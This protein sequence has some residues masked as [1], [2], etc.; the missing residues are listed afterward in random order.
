[1]LERE[2]GV[3]EERISWRLG[4]PGDSDSLQTE[5]RVDFRGSSAHRDR[6]AIM[7]E[8]AEAVQGGR[9][10]LRLSPPTL[11]PD[12]T[13]PT[14]GA[15]TV[16][17]PDDEPADDV[18]SRGPTQ[19]NGESAIDRGAPT[20]P[21]GHETL[22]IM[23]D[24]PTSAHA[25]LTARI[26]R[27]EAD[28]R[29]W[30]NLA[31]TLNRQGRLPEAVDAAREAVRLAPDS[32][33]SQLLLGMLFRE[34]DRF[35]DALD[36]FAR[37]EAI[38]PEFPRLRANRGVV[39]FFKGDSEGAVRELEAALVEDGRDRISLFNLAVILVSRHRFGAAQS[40]F[41]RLIELEPDR[42]RHYYPFL[43]ELGRVQTIEE[44]LTQAHRIKNFIGIVGDRLRRICEEWDARLEPECRDALAGVRSDQEKVYTDMVVFLG[45]IR[46]RPMKLESVALPRLLDRIVFVASSATQGVTI[47]RR[48]GED[49][50]PLEC[51]VDMLQEVFLNLLLNA[52]DAVRAKPP[53]TEGEATVEIEVRK[54]GS[55]L[56]VEI[57]DNGIGI[58][59]SDLGQVF[60][61]GYTTKALGSGIGLAHAKRVIESHGGS[62]RIESEPGRGTAVTCSLPT[63][64]RVG[65]TLVNLAF[66]SQLLLEPHELILEEGGEDLGI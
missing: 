56:E 45:A 57:R 35:D 47:R 33:V 58:G 11:H 16:Q 64:A 50:P 31:I 19:P 54:D 13:L 39:L 53:A 21:A 23:R 52:I 18:P 1:M 3:L 6:P 38:D 30:H 37:V 49:L 40:C 15:M 24:D 22:R 8:S 5:P 43:V 29:T 25:R 41:E 59:A 36:A 66:R 17:I 60:Q 46:P 65:E 42:A 27:G 26:E 28:Y 9:E 4:L 12:S 32:A 55:W 10:K 62:I 20:V 61:L 2:D 44:T 63:S 14:I 7:P 51:D 48:T 34:A